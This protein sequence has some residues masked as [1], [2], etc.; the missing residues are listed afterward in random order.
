MLLLPQIKDG[1]TELAGP[2]CRGRK[3]FCSMYAQTTLA[4][5]DLLV[6]LVSVLLAPGFHLFAQLHYDAACA[7]QIC[8]DKGWLLDG[9]PLSKRLRSRKRRKCAWCETTRKTI[10]NYL[11]WS[12]KK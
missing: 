3:L 10:L 7:H 2:F 5:I 8:E 1:L 4:V 12:L 6:V 9:R 11:G